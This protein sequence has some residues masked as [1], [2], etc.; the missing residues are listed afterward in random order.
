MDDDLNED[1][2]DRFRLRMLAEEDRTFAQARME[3]EKLSPEQRAQLRKAISDAVGIHGRLVA[4]GIESFLPQFQLLS[5]VEGASSPD[6]TTID[7]I[8]LHLALVAWDRG[9]DYLPRVWDTPVK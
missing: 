3:Y 1:D 5:W 9:E 7:S 2:L 8:P 4:A 6:L